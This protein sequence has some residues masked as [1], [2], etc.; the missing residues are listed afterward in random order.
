MEAPNATIVCGLRKP[1]AERDL[2]GR[3]EKMLDGRKRRLGCDDRLRIEKAVGGVQSAG[4]GGGKI[5]LTE[6][7]N[8]TIVCGLRKPQVECD[9][10]EEKPG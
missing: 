9:L 3:A 10:P 2:P 4:E 7:P 8:A 5:R 6:A 1:R